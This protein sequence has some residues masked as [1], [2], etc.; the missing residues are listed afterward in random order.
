M[1]SL[2]AFC[3]RA[4]AMT[5]GVVM[6]R[7]TKI[8]LLVGLAFIIVI[9]ILLSD[10][11]NQAGDP[12]RASLTDGT[13]SLNSSVNAPNVKQPGT[14]DVMV[15]APQPVIPQNRIKTESDAETRQNNG[16]TIVQISP[17]GDPSRIPLP[18]RQTVAQGPTQIQDNNDL[19]GGQPPVVISEGN[20][21]NQVA[22]NSRPSNSETTTSDSAMTR[23]QNEARSREVE[24]VSRDGSPVG[25][26]PAPVRPVMTPVA[27]PQGRQIVAEENDTVSKFASK[28]MGAN[29]KANRDAIIKANASVGPD[30]SKVIV[31]HTYIVPGAAAQPTNPTPSVAT[32][33]P[34]QLKPQVIEPAPAPAPAQPPRCTPS[35]KTT[36][37]GKSPPNNSAAAH[38]TPRS[39]NSI[40]TCSKATPRSGRICD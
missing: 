31:G 33:P 17:G 20:N 19:G 39:P 4:I 24:I 40:K 27:N 5:F 10:H 29:S 38:V 13:Q 14:T 25:L 37:S 8:G 9:G 26:S 28:Y 3:D 21:N 2:L 6:T 16:N 23:L 11:I 34:V 15:Q 12:L 30:G 1:R 22:N 7:E 36:R 32:A 35:R 18:P